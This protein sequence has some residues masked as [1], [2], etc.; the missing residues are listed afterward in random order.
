MT[1]AP[2]PGSADWLKARIAEH[3]AAQDNAQ[4]QA[5]AHAGAWQAY[6]R[7]LD[8]M[9]KEPDKSPAE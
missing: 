2:K 3:K 6:Q 4:A 7:L 9:M 1:D 5:H 8:E